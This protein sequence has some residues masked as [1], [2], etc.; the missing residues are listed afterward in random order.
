MPPC[1]TSSGPHGLIA[2]L[3]LSRMYRVSKNLVF[4]GL[5][6]YRYTRYTTFSCIVFRTL[7]TCLQSELHTKCGEGAGERH[8]HR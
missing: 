2:D 7:V 1:P 6:M 4:F 5:C 3:K 8:A